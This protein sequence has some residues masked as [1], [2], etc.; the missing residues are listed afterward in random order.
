MSRNRLHGEAAPRYLPPPMSGTLLV[1]G[2]QRPRPN[3]AAALSRVGV[4]GRVAVITAG[5]RHDEAELGPLERDLPHP[6][7][8]LPLYAWF[9]EVLAANPDLQAAYRVRQDRIQAFKAL[10]RVR[11]SAAYQTVLRLHA[12]PVEDAALHAAE[13]ADAVGTIRRL[14]ARVPAKCSEIRAASG[15]AAAPW[16][17]PAV[18]AYRA[19]IADTLAGCSGLA[20]AGGHVAILLNRMQLFGFEELLPAFLDQ[21]GVIAAWSAGAMAL[22]ERVVLFYDDPPRGASEPEVLDQGFGVLRGRVLFPHARRRL[23]LDDPDRL[24][25][26]QA[27]FGRCIALENGADIEVRGDEWTQRCQPGCCLVLAP[28]ASFPNGGSDA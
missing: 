8:H 23:R 21:G 9:E 25:L 24:R 15:V 3:L 14:D 20:I 10:Y 5:W 12:G 2:P 1:L 18:A 22:T 11:L 4:S 27:R 6:L 16:Q 7:V 19:R 13:L 26:L 28:G 17:H